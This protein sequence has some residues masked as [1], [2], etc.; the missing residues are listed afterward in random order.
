VNIKIIE[1][2]SRNVLDST[3]KWKQFRSLSFEELFENDAEAFREL[4]RESSRVLVEKA[5][6]DLGLT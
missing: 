1:L 4:Y 6:A 2:A 5:L 3:R